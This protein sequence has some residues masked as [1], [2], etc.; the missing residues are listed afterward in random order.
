MHLGVQGRGSGIHGG[1]R[2]K[3][4]EPLLRRARAGAAVHKREG[5]RWGGFAHHAEAT[6]AGTQLARKR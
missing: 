4:A 5:K 3:G 6:G 2:R 1:R